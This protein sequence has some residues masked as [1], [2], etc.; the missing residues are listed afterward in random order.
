MKKIA[1]ALFGFSLFLSLTLNTFAKELNSKELLKTI[2]A[3]TQW[4]K[5]SQ[6]TN[7]HFHYEYMPFLDRYIQDDHIVRQA[8]TVFILSEVMKLDKTNVFDLKN[9]VENGLKY[10]NEN[11][12]AGDFNGYEFRCVKLDETQCTLG[13]GS[14]ALI[15]Y[16]NLVEKYPKLTNKYSD[17]IQQNLN[18]I[19][20]MKLPGKGFRGSYYLSGNQTET[21]S[22]FYDGEA[23]LALTNYYR[24]IPDQEI[25]KIIDEAMDYFNDH[26]S[27]AWNNNFYLWGMAALKN[28]YQIDPQ[29]KYFKFTK[30]YTD[31]RISGYKE[32]RDTNRNV[33][34]YLE[35]I[36][37]AYSILE[38]NISK[39]EK[40][41][42]LEEINYWLTQSK[43]LQIKRSDKM[44]VQINENKK[45]RLGLK[46]ASRAIGGF[47][48]G[49]NEPVLRID[50]TQHCLSSNLQKYVDID[51][52]SL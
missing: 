18:F 23:L 6:E 10:L 43:N 13:G 4:L 33:C 51:K 14:L 2:T 35:G 9:T 8:G 38:Q 48:S 41:S 29:E 44:S 21:E 49:L 39:A 7:G 19:L 11:S 15:A 32:K 36:V 47:L 12:I 26:Y 16:L 34:A 1:Y 42:Y 27:K 40:D 20:A 37:S 30:D 17:L 28:L 50:F 46:K 25:K 5:Q 45:Q 31:W 22:D 52:Q 3:A 24:K